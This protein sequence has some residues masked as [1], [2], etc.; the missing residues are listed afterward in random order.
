MPV[1]KRAFF[2]DKVYQKKI[3]FTLI[4]ICTSVFDLCIIDSDGKMNNFF[5]ISHE[6]Y[7]NMYRF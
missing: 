7:T 3:I 1:L 5:G 2:R 6:K 4:F